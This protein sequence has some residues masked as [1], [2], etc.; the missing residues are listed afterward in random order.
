MPLLPADPPC[1]DDG[2]T[3]DNALER[4]DHLA[5]LSGLND[6]F[7]EL[8]KTVADLRI[9]AVVWFAVSRELREWRERGSHCDPH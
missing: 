4:L 2:H 3:R 6:A 7:N 8:H 5:E 9:P 1:F